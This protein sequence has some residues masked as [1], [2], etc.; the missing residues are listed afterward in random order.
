MSHLIPEQRV[1]KNGVLTTKHVR[2]GAKPST[3]R[4]AL[5]APKVAAGNREAAK[6]KKPTK[7]QLTKYRWSFVAR[8]YDDQLAQV[9]GISSSACLFVATE[10]EIYGMLCG[11]NT[12]DALLMMQAGYRTVTSA[13]TVLNDN[14]MSHLLKERD[15]PLKA[16]ERRIPALAFVRNTVGVTEERLNGPH[17]LDSVEASG[18]A[19]LDDNYTWEVEQGLIRLSDIKALGATRI[20]KADSWT[21]IGE[22]LKNIAAGRVSYSA[23]DM[24]NLLDK[25]SSGNHVIKRGLRLLDS[26][27]AD[28][29]EKIPHPSL[30]VI[31]MHDDMLDKGIEPAERR[32]DILV[33]ANSIFSQSNTV[34]MGDSGMSTD[35]IIRFHD[36]GVSTDDVADKKI[37]IN[38]LDAIENNGIAPSVSGGWL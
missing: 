25:N 23:E 1:D 11:M 28:F 12:G 22:A 27:G 21:A 18:I 7:Q 16:L 3:A 24:R 17:F 19:A 34:Y 35:D 10:Q 8:E 15:M 32:A 20:K 2:V 31:D 26:Y 29:I 37:T 5:P 14:G 4:S 13:E 36:A 9:L 33:Y 6:R 30:G 38:Q